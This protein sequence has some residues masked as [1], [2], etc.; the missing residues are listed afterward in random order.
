M[1]ADDFGIEQIVAEDRFYRG[2]RFRD[3]RAAV[4]CQPLAGRRGREGAS[5]LPRYETTVASVFRGLLPFGW[6]YWNEPSI[7]TRIRAGATTAGDFAAF[8]TRTAYASPASGKLRSDRAP[9]DGT[10]ELLRLDCRVAFGQ[11]RK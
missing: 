9:F 1:E 6:H 5:P 11:R 2:S 10:S 4:F 8:S 7:P 3:V